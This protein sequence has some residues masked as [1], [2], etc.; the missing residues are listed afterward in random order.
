MRDLE[1]FVLDFCRAAGG[2]VEPPAYGIYDVLLPEA[3]ARQL[4]VAT[5]QR[6]TFADEESG[7]ATHLTYGHPL[8][9]RMVDAARAT[10]ACA[11]YYINPARVEKRGLAD[12]ARAALSFPNARLQESPGS[13]G[14]KALFH[15]L[16]VNF[17]ASLVTDEKR[18]QLVAIWMD[19]QR[20]SAV[21][22]LAAA[23]Y[24]HLE[25][26]CQLP[27]L[28]VA[29][30]RWLDGHDPSSPEAMAA[31]LD[32]AAQAAVVP[33]AETIA[34]LHTRTA[35]H[36]AL[37]RARLEQYYDDTEADLVKRWQRSTDE[38]KRESLQARLDATRADRVA[39]LADAE[40]KYRLRLELEP[41]NAALVGQPKIQLP[42]RIANRHA[43]VERMVIW[44]PLR[45]IVEP[46]LCDV[47]LRPST[48]L[49]LCAG[50]HLA[51]TDAA[52]AAPQCADCKRFYCRHCAGELVACAVC[53]RPICRHSQVAC[54][55][56]GRVTCRAHAGLCH[57]A[58]GQ[59]RRAEATAPSPTAQR[60]P[61]PVPPAP[62]AL[63]AGGLATTTVRGRPEPKADRR[64]K[65]GGKVSRTG[66]GRHPARS[67]GRSVP[68]TRPAPEYSSFHLAVVVDQRESAVYAYVS[69]SRGGPVIAERSWVLGPDGIEIQC[70]CARAYLCKR[71]HNYLRPGSADRIEAQL[72]YGVQ[73]MREEFD[74]APRR[75]TYAMGLGQGNVRYVPR[76]RLGGKWKDE[77]VLAASRERFM[78]QY[79][80]E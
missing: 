61:S 77:G 40:A 78:E 43:D 53:D 25:T 19:V 44:D 50:G 23:S 45:H 69:E 8:V 74:I 68:T 64:A 14:G 79:G 6:L 13:T 63:P 4:G 58:D 54:P 65:A 11:R 46:M 24:V 15:Y 52:C 9:E 34:L 67:V 12:L 66:M 5:L 32:R 41:V 17:K 2:I 60:A 76:L 57:A 1:Q 80:E 31:L 62:T 51:C 75:V 38:S 33:L 16:L 30:V 59:P 7:Q 55:E 10:P 26:E 72:E 35:R 39:K 21:H 73:L 42:V 48:T 18:E 3:T 37:D 47:C 70:D 56:C 71:T 22:D 20:G 27:H 29:P 49:L 28:P 36:L